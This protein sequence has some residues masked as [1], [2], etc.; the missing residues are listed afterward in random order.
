MHPTKC[1]SIG[2]SRNEAA[3]DGGADADCASAALAI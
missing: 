3:D 1:N 2:I